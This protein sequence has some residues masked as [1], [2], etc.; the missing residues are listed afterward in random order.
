MRR[1]FDV[2]KRKRIADDA[3]P[4]RSSK[5]DNRHTG[6]IAFLAG[7]S[8]GMRQTW[9]IIRPANG[10]AHG[11]NGIKLAGIAFARRTC[12]QARSFIPTFPDFIPT[13]PG[14]IPLFPDFIPT[15]PGF[16]PPFP[17]FIPQA[18]NFRPT[19]TVKNGL[20]EPPIPQKCP[21]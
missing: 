1:E 17:D 10:L 6:I 2:R 21:K 5:F 12:P 14:F 9:A 4:A 13:F 16:S 11:A 19:E 8:T 20:F 18:R 7:T 15:F 3:P